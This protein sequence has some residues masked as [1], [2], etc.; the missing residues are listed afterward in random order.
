MKTDIYVVRLNQGER[1]NEEIKQVL[2]PADMGS[3]GHFAVP[4]DRPTE[5]HYHDYDEYWYFTEGGTTVTLRT[6][7][8]TSSSYRIGPGDLVVTPKGVEH[9]H[10]PDDVVKGIQWVSV[11]PPDAR[12]GHLH[13]VL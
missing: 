6:P 9:G 5:L 10:I 7:D 8:G 1:L 12:R 11:I 13:R 3:I 4:K 2:A